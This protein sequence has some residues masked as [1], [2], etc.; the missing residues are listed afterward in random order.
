M[1]NIIIRHFNNCQLLGIIYPVD[2]RRHSLNK[3][4]SAL[5]TVK[6]N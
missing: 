1:Q 3:V 4:F 2:E 6:V 5:T